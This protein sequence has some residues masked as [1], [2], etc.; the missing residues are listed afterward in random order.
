[1]TSMNIQ[2]QV[3]LFVDDAAVYLTVTSQND[4]NILQ[5]DF[6]Y[7]QEWERTG[8]WNLIQENARFCI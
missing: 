2:S 4:R 1:M 7:L 3:R 5:S 6:N 8:T